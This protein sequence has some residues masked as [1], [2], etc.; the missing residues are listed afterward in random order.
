ML[1][2]SVRPGSMDA[3]IDLATARA[4]DFASF[5]D[6][7]PGIRIVCFNGRTAA[8]LFRRL[9]AS[10]LQKSSN[11]LRCVTLPSTSPAFAAMSFEE[12]LERWRLVLG[13]RP[14]TGETQ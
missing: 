3:A 6:A 8:S 10:T 12:K 7:H 1:E 5:F 4:N 11:E 14:I 13:E 9:V 2:A